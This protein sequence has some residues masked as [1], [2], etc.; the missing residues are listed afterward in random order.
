MKI[1][2]RAKIFNQIELGTAELFLLMLAKLTYNATSCNLLMHEEY[3]VP[4]GLR[5]LLFLS[6]DFGIKLIVGK[7]LNVILLI[8]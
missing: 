7:P 2:L 1:H 3:Q 5:N 4:S 8:K 6:T